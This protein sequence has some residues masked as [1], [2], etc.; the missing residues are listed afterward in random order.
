[1]LLS[2]FALPNTYDLLSVI[3]N[4]QAPFSVI[5]LLSRRIMAS[6]VLLCRL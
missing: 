2:E 1:M 5:D 6:C 3:L 4:A